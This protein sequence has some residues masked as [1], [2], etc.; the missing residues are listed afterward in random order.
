MW[1]FVG[2]RIVAT[3]PVMIVV[4]LAVFL[5]LRLSPGDPAAIIAGDY[6]TAYHPWRLAG[7][8][9]AGRRQASV[10]TGSARRSRSWCN[11]RRIDLDQCTV[12][13][14]GSAALG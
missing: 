9:S 5:L 12:E 14:C 10:R 3:I 4:A 6:A 2:K 1:G 11:R 7:K 8:A 13:P